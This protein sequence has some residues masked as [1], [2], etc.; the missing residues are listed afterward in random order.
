MADTIS[1]RRIVIP[2][3]Y[4]EYYQ[5][6]DTDLSTSDYQ[7]G[8]VI[9]GYDCKFIAYL[10]PR[11][12]YSNSSFA[13]SYPIL[14]D[15]PDYPVCELV[16]GRLIPVEF[17]DEDMVFDDEFDEDIESSC[18]VNCN[19]VFRCPECLEYALVCDSPAKRGP[20]YYERFV[21]KRCGYET[22]SEDPYSEDIESS[23]RVEASLVEP[24]QEVVD[25]LISIL[26]Q[27]GFVLDPQ[28]PKNPGKTWMGR[29]HLQVINEDS[30][31]TEFPEIKDYVVPEMVSAISE[32]SDRSD[33]PITWSF[34]A[35]A[36]GQVTGGLDVDKQYIP[37]EI[38]STTATIEGA[39]YGGAY[40]IDPEQYF[41]RDD[42]TELGEDVC[43]RLNRVYLDEDFDVV[44]IYMDTPKRLFISVA[45]PNGDEFQT[46]VDI[47]M[48]KIRY[49]R[50]L[51]NKYGGFIAGELRAQRD[52]FL[53][54]GYSST[55]QPVESAEGD[56]PSWWYE[57]DPEPEADDAAEYI[58]VK[59]V[60]VPIHVDPDGAWDWAS[61][62]FSWAESPDTRNGDWHSD[63][64]N[65]IYITD[66]V[67][68][69]E[70]VGDMISDQVPD[71]EG[72]YL[73]SCEAHLVYALLGVYSDSYYVGPS[74]TDV[75]TEYFTDDVDV[76][77][78]PRDSSI[79]HFTF[80][81][82]G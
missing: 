17:P 13:D 20:E 24:P 10:E 66:S 23:E 16:G 79:T 8:D 35:N 5:I 44:E 71:T 74:V 60:D 32:L 19:K 61:D 36:S 27:Y 4:D 45:D 47:D 46:Y 53:S 30:Y 55:K 7:L 68:V 73:I 62:D 28:F 38:S 22:Y 14:T 12:K 67:S 76:E 3:P 50:D 6:D 2:E 15:D 25:E 63:E 9:D 56:R 40:D 77:F 37:D 31:V 54:E 81:R 43:G 57:P 21:C 1:N 70:T 42:L 69:S 49:P 34:G 29:T 75:G 33:C 51:V 58:D 18:N 65:N 82:I 59:L 41:T 39:N 64:Y 11:S 72:D 52:A 26:A 78:L 48:R 80:K